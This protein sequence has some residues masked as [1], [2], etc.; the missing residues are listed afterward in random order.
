MPRKIVKK[1]A[2]KLRA[3]HEE[4]LI[5]IKRYPGTSLALGVLSVLFGCGNPFVMGAILGGFLSAKQIENLKQKHI[6]L[7]MILTVITGAMLGGLSIVCTVLVGAHLG[8]MGCL[9]G[10]LTGVVFTTLFIGQA[11]VF[12]VDKIIQGKYK[13]KVSKN[14]HTH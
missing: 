14:I 6:E 10:S 12:I 9:L 11:S 1:I 8:S 3:R 4:V 13:L 5:M 2:N 7:Q